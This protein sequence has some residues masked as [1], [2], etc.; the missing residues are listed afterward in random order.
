MREIE[1]KIYK[2]LLTA[3]MLVFG[4]GSVF[5]APFSIADIIQASQLA[6]DDFQTRNPDHVTHFNGFKV[7][8]SGEEAKVKVY[9]NHD[10]MSMEF[11]Y[12]CHKHDSEIECHVQ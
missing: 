1:M 2:L 10:G 8:P 6:T 4:G 7:W 12:L 9:V 11:N 5:A 3:S